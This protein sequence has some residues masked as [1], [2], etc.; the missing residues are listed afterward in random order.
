[1]P[2][3]FTATNV[4]LRPSSC[5]RWVGLYNRVMAR[6][7]TGNW[8]IFLGL[9]AA[10]AGCSN[11]NA[12]LNDP[13]VRL[14]NRKQNQTRSAIFTQK[15]PADNDGYFVGLSLSG[16]GS[17]SA[18]FSAACMFQ[19]ERLGILQKV[20][21]I[22]AVSG[23]SLPAAY[24]CLND[25]DWNPGNV[26]KRLVHPFAS[27]LL[28][29]TF[30]EPWNTLGLMF[31]SLN[32]SDLLARSFDAE[33]YSRSGRN[34]TFAD[35]R[36][37]R[38]RLL[39]NA[40]DLQSGRRFVFCNE[41]FNQLN[42]DLSKYSISYAVA[43]SSAVPVV[44]HPVTIEDYST[45]YSAYHHLIDGGVADNLGIVTLVETYINQVTLAEQE[46]LPDPYPNGAVL[47]VVDSRARFNG[48]QS[49]EADVGSLDILRTAFR[50]TSNTLL[51][52]ASTATITDLIV[53]NAP[54]NTTARQIRNDIQAL[55]MDGY[56]EMRDR[57]G[58]KVT[59]I[60]FSL[61]Q[62][63]QLRD[64]P[65]ESFRQTIN[66]ISTYFNIAPNEA[67]DLYQAADLLVKEKLETHLRDVAQR[68]HPEA[69]TRP[70]IAPSTR[71]AP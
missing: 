39:I 18:N 47:I 15:P 25:R 32:R 29:Q 26:Q 13:H 8:T 5:E 51:N 28:V 68:L 24:Y 1:M 23:G 49:N 12:P 57:T 35:L 66:S 60:Y 27:D 42:S 21:Y 59:V 63:D 20:D 31:T 38:P 65:F 6:T 33:L 71:Y 19:L 22:S 55:Q 45:T 52:R 61:S 48:E 67:F 7:A 69:T 16:G 36:A 3:S 44:L 62:V 70:A 10:L 11:G 17:R 50:L 46:H 54:D 37:D 64:V 30:L 53:N 41:T 58:H 4:S 40:T 9:L 56:L 2:S 14:E 34:L 43:A